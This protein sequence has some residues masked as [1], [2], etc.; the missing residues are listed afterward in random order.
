MRWEKCD[1]LSNL[2][3]FLGITGVLGTY[4]PNY[5]LRTHELQKMTRKEVPFEWGPKQ[6]ESMTKVKEGVK[7]AKAL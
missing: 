1:N 3:G 2:R 4:I 6:I 5:A 7:A